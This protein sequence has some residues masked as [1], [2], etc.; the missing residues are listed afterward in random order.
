MQILLQLKHLT[1]SPIQVCNH[2]LFVLSTEF[3]YTVA[4]LNA[5]P[6]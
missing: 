1:L 3:L 5:G 2:A 6:H 4:A